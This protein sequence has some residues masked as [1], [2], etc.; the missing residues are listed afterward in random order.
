M[1]FYSEWH[2][3][4][5]FWRGAEGLLP[6]AEVDPDWALDGRSVSAA[7]DELRALLTMYI[8]IQF[9]DD[10]EL[11]AK[12]VPDYPPAAKRIIRDNGIWA[13]TLQRDNVHLVTEGIAFLRKQAASEGLT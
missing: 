4:W 6:Y 1:P 9:P 7:N 5:L 11:G 12:V 8:E 10:P 2:R 13:A 3:C